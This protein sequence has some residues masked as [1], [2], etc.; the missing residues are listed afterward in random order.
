MT[1]QQKFNR[2]LYRRGSRGIK[3]ISGP[4]LFLENMAGVGCGELV[5]ISGDPINE[6]RSLPDASVKTGQVLQVKD[7]L[8]VVQIFDDT[9]GLETGRSTVWMEG[10]AAKVGVG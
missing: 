8:C 9:V 5:T 4:L 2:K 6:G 7:D 3:S 1:P 10:D